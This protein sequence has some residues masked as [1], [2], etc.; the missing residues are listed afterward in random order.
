MQQQDRTLLLK[1]K[2][3]YIDQQLQREGKHLYPDN[4]IL[5]ELKRKKLQIKD[6]LIARTTN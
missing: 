1:R 2:H 3:S 6:E 5:I 4:L